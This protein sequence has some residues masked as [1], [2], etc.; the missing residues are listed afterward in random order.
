MIYEITIILAIASI[1]FILARRWR[2]QKNERELYD[3]KGDLD[4]EQFWQNQQ[5]QDQPK[6]D[7]KKI[8][9]KKAEEL[10]KEKRLKEAE[11][12]YL[13]V[14]AL[15]P[16]NAKIYGRLGVIYFKSGNFKDAQE[17]FLNAIRLDPENGFY[18]NNLGLV[19]F[20]QGKYK[21]ALLYFENAV[22]IDEKNTKR[23]VSLGLCYE[24]LG[25]QEKAK[26]AWGKA[27]ELEPKNEEY[28]KLIEE[29]YPERLVP[30]RV[31][32]SR[33]VENRGKK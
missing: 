16:E 29:V 25:K 26:E 31:E 1:F 8:Y 27:V 32:G 17:A 30:S 2:S 6:S 20:T 23:W 13:K 21:Q 7:E 28:R 5:E 9:L 24:K 10:F 15:L 33:G 4:G 12:Y 18:Q 19:L 14:V 22:D 3:I 11:K